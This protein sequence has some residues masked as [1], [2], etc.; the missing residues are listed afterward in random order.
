MVKDRTVEFRSAIDA[1]SGG[2]TALAAVQ[3]P[4]HPRQSPFVEHA[5]DTSRAFSSVSQKLDQL[6]KRTSTSTSVDG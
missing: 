4:V 2:R 6:L 5:T 3:Q 1:F